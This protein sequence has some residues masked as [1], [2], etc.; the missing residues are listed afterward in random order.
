MAGDYVHHLYV[1][2]YAKAYPDAKVIGVDGLGEK[3]QDVKFTGGRYLEPKH[4]NF[5]D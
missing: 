2:D 3:R 4:A 5:L 1:G